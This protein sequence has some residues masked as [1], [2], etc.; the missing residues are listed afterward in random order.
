M[1]VVEEGR[2]EAQIDRALVVAVDDA[3]NE[4]P[5]SYGAEPM[6]VR[7]YRHSLYRIW[8]PLRDAILALTPVE[9]VGNAEAAFNAG[10]AE[11]VQCIE[12]EGPMAADHMARDTTWEA[13]RD[14]LSTPATAQECSASPSGYHQ[15]DTSMESGPNNCF[16]C[17]KPM[18]GR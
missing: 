2:R 10:W 13:Y 12:N 3:I 14:A 11:A 17:E 9:G 8:T 18:G 6:E 15:V 1:T 7:D 16:H 4:P 5:R